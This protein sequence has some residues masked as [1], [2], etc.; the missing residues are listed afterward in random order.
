MALAVAFAFSSGLYAR[1]SLVPITAPSGSPQAGHHCPGFWANRAG[2]RCGNSTYGRAHTNPPVREEPAWDNVQT[3]QLVERACF[4][5]HSN[6]TEWPW[7]SH[8]APVSWLVQY[9]VDEGRA[10]LN[11]SE[12]DRPQDEAHE[13]AEEVEEGEMPLPIFLITHPDARLSDAERAQLI[14][15]LRATLGE[16]QAHRGE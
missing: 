6:E 2:S 16:E 5:C 1:A 3:R 13:A 11:F 7:Y 4:D 9:D 10:A 12:F 8:V 14:Q 15:G